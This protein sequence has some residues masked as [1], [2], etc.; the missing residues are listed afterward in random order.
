MACSAGS[1]AANVLQW[2]R[3]PEHQALVR[4]VLVLFNLFLLL[5][6][7]VLLVRA[8]TSLACMPISGRG[9]S[10]FELDVSEPTLQLQVVRMASATPLAYISCCLG[11]TWSGSDPEV[12][13]P[14]SAAV[15]FCRLFAP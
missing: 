10:K 9:A 12:P 4:E 6:Y 5:A 15:L 7:S 8:C 3:S 2:S 1:E 11:A 13:L 14:L